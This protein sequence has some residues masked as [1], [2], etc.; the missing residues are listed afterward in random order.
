MVLQVDAVGQVDMV[1]EVVA[2][3]EYDRTAVIFEVVAADG[4]G[5]DQSGRIKPANRTIVSFSLHATKE[6]KISF[7]ILL[8]NF[9]Q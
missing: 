6:S 4:P 7:S 5:H 1:P 3:R 9:H 8:L 2:E